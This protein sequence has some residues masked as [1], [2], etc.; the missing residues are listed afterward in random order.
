MDTCPKCNVNSIKCDRM[1]DTS[2]LLLNQWCGGELPNAPIKSFI[3]KK[4]VLTFVLLTFSAAPYYLYS[5]LSNKTSTVR[6]IITERGR[7]GGSGDTEMEIVMTPRWDEHLRFVLEA[8]RWC[9]A[10][11]LSQAL[12]PVKMLRWVTTLNVTSGKDQ[13]YAVTSGFWCYFLVSFWPRLRQMLS[14]RSLRW[15]CVNTGAVIGGTTSTT[16]SSRVSWTRWGQIDG[17][18]NQ[19]L[20]TC[21]LC[22]KIKGS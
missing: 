6:S 13:V 8:C 20:L 19:H 1:L 7:Q 16:T 18:Q 12:Q 4:L 9:S 2:M 3:G 14:L 17:D 5:V 21:S 11:S 15:S 10:A 22:R